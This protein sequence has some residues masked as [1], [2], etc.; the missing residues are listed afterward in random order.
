MFTVPAIGS[1]ITVPLIPGQIFSNNNDTK[2]IYTKYD[3][4]MPTKVDKVTWKRWLGHPT[5]MLL[6]LTTNIA[7]LLFNTVNTLSKESIRDLKGDK[8]RL[9]EERNTAHR[10]MAKLELEKDSIQNELTK[11]ILHTYVQKNILNQLRDSTINK[12]T[13]P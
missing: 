3:M 5:T 2:S 7:M 8:E 10:T 1:L 6:I 12:I 4:P 11:L 9:I 13:T